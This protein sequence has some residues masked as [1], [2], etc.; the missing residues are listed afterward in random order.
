MLQ[1]VRTA[2]GKR[3]KE[4][5]RRSSKEFEFVLGRQID[6]TSVEQRA[7]N[8]RGGVPKE[9]IDGQSDRHTYSKGKGK[10]RPKLTRRICFTK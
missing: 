3:R 4:S 10:S 9:W 1:R 5:G 8:G 7:R 6:E 2:V